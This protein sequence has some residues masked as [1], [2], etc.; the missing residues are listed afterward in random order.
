[1]TIRDR[2]PQLIAT[3]DG[4]FHADEVVGVTVAMRL[5]PRAR[6]LRTRDPRLLRAAD[7][8][9]DVGGEYRP[10][11]GRFD[12]HQRGFDERRDTP[13]EG[14]GR[15]ASAGLV[16]RHF[17]ATYLRSVCS[18]FVDTDASSW[19]PEVADAVDRV[20]MRIVDALDCGETLGPSSS[21]IS[22]TIALLNPN[23]LESRN[24]TPAQ[25]DE[26]RQRRFAEAVEVTGRHLEGLVRQQLSGIMTRNMVLGARVTHEGAVLMLPEGGM[27]WQSV[28]MASMPAVRFVVH[29]DGSDRF[30]V[31]GVPRNSMTRSLRQ[32]LPE[33]WAALEGEA[34]AS[35]CGVND[36]LFCHRNLFLCGAAS[37]TGALAMANAACMALSA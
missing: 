22:T 1:M 8:C 33:T 37:L 12:H 34:L 36:A 2:E 16:W 24:L 29:A 11:V 7:M 6:L 3:H 9:V 20:F 18:H 23:W 19:L 4:T 28:V 32:T 25:L 26:L 15:L 5:W 17:G 21:S 30:L 31:Q 10:E 13:G 27:P 35:T 14:S